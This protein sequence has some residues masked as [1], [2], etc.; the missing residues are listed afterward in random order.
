[1]SN[2]LHPFQIRRTILLCVLALPV[3]PLV[4]YLTFS[5]G[6]WDLNPGNWPADLRSLCA[7]LSL[8]FA[9][10]GSALAVVAALEYYRKQ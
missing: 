9:A 5:F 3:G 2:T 8:V 6:L 7:F 4:L 10:A 1:M